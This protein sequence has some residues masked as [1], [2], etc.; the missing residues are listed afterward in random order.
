MS[1]IATVEQLEAIYGQPNEASTVKV[2]A[3]ITPQYRAL[4]DKSPFAALAT[5]GPEGLD[6]SP[7]GDVCGFVRVHDEK[8]LMIPDRRGNNRVDSLRNI[9]R[10]PRV[11]LLFLIPG[12]GSTLRVNGR[13][14]VSV[15]P[16]LLVSFEVDGTAP[17]TV[18]IITVDEIYFQCARAIVRSDLWNPDKRVDPK[19]LPTPGQILADMSDNRVGGEHYDRAWPERARQSLW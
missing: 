4:I 7:R 16:D 2:S 13:A 3:K 6:C 11:A 17:R 18:I 12:S 10:D 19:T 9:V 1:I 15:H 5:C 8:T 14:Q